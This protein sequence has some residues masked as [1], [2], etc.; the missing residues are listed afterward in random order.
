EHPGIVPVHDAGALPDGRVFYVMKRVRGERLDAWA[1]RH[2]DRRIHLR[3]YQRICE[4]VAFAHAHGVIHRDLKPENVMVGEFGE[5]LVMDW[6]IAK[7]LVRT[8]APLEIADSRRGIERVDVT[9]DTMPAHSD[10]SD[11]AVGTVMG[12]LAYMPPE[13]ARGEVD[14]L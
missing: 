12:T 11:T 14:S 3:L 7:E 13:Q 6:G 9:A 4:A 10:S 8:P 2:T 1:L 5:A